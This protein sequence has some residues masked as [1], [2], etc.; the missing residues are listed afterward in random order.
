MKK[1][2]FAQYEERIKKQPSIC[3]RF[4]IKDAQEA[5]DAMPDGPNV[6]YYQDEILLCSQEL[7]R[8]LKK[9]ENREPEYHAVLTEVYVIL[10][11]AGYCTNDILDD[12][13][14]LVNDA[15]RPA[16]EE[17]EYKQ[18]CKPKVET[19]REFGGLE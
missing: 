14:D 12:L 3:L 5:I 8:R 16:T 10:K 1:M 15:F 17:D 13:K 11:N 9:R 6:G 7:N 2:Q 18:S 19:Q 4:T